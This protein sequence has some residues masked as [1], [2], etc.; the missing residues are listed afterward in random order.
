MDVRCERCKAEYEFD[1]RR[2]GE[3]G[4]A[5]K[6]AT[7]GHIFMV[8]RP[9]RAPVAAPSAAAAGPERVRDW[10]LRQPNGH[11][12]SFRDLTTLQRWISERKATRSDEVSVDGSPWRKLGAVAELA[13][14][15]AAAAGAA[16]AGHGDVPAEAP[17]PVAPVT[18]AAPRPPS[19]RAGPEAFSVPL[20]A[21]QAGA[22][23]GT[24]QPPAA[25]D[26][27]AVPLPGRSSPRDPMEAIPLPGATGSSPSARAEVESE[28]ELE[29]VPLPGV[30]AS[31][32]PS[33]AT[34][35]EDE[36]APPE[37]A[38]MT[39]TLDSVPAPRPVADTT[40]ADAASEVEWPAPVLVSAHAPERAAPAQVTSFPDARRFTP[41][42][43]PT[44]EQPPAAPAPPPVE[45]AAKPAPPVEKAP[46]P[47]RPPTI[48][49][50]P[51]A[52]LNMVS[53]K[54]SSGS[55]ALRWGVLAV[56]ALGLGGAGAYY[57]RTHGGVGPAATVRADPVAKTGPVA[58]KTAP[59]VA[60]TEPV[61]A[62]T[63][64]EVAK[65]E[66]AVAKTE[67]VVAKAEPA[68]AKTEPAVAKT[69]PAEARDYHWYLSHA[70]RLRNREHSRAAV[71]DYDHAIALEPNHPEP[72]SGKGLAL[73]DLGKVASAKP[74]FARALQLNPRY[75]VALMGMAETS[76][77]L[78]Q[79]ADAIRFYKRFLDIQPTGPEAFAA[80][81]AI[82]RLQTP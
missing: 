68:V 36:L 47:P 31:A 58:T 6:C 23:A 65:T 56:V 33:A 78:G 14:F 16:H 77:Q 73:L 15:F 63:E 28:A 20:P 42:P 81:S 41:S 71:S 76:R 40:P 17:P 62:K 61:V 79:N 54:S 45:V 60:K 18:Q 80:K 39:E 11:T 19:V 9:I 51:Q 50:A 75:G 21:P 10:K 52:S 32:G 1:E 37:A 24:S 48:P 26:E 29:T 22:A 66:P 53:S 12:Y 38:S 70:D 35:F 72:Y 49:P 8:R 46:S 4:V 67:S 43:S 7:C 13:P 64:P 55:G 69:E 25:S 82:E 74:M 27:D 44:V 3:S 5:V 57:L 2:I 59:A 34:L 30:T